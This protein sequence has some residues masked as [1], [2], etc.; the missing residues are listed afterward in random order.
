M[1][2]ASRAFAFVATIVTVNATRQ[3]MDRNVVGLRTKSERK[4]LSATKQNC[5]LMDRVEL[6]IDPL[7]GPQAYKHVLFSFRPVIFD[8]FRDLDLTMNDI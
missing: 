1:S 7:H 5:L 3:F 6:W 2:A 4:V 8:K